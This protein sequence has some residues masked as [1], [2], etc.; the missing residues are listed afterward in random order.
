[1]KPYG[2]FSDDF[3]VNL[4]VGTEMDLPSSRD[5]VLH[6]F[7]QLR[8]RFPTLRNFYGRDRGEY[9]IE[10]DKDKGNYRWASVDPKRICSGYVNPP[11]VAVAY[12]QHAVVL[13]MIPYTLSVSPL[14]CES[15]NVMY[16][17]DFN[18]RGNQNEVIADALGLPPAFER[19][20]EIEGTSLLT[21]EPSFQL[22][23]DD[24]CRTQI[25]IA[26][27]TRTT[28]YHIRTRDFPEEQ[29]S[30]Y[31][32]ARRL[33]SLEAGETFVDAARRLF[34]IAEEILDHVM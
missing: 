28:A 6:H 7:E 29:L 17:F 33:G 5:S 25:R 26:F 18:F 8:R 14:D 34:V 24:D 13:E 31:L 19:L 11:E 2:S 12:E 3:Y 21:Q 9:V 20:R 27:E 23:M 30:A 16:G 1:M 15:I 22:A 4:H 32:T 10:E